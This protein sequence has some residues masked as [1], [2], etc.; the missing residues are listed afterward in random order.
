MPT[1]DASFNPPAPVTD[2]TVAHPATGAESGAM[3]GK[4]DTTFSLSN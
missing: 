1:Y 2:V 3:R 4:L